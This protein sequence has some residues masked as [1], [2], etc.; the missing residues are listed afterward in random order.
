MMMTSTSR[1]YQA[2]DEKEKRNIAIEEF[3]WK[4]SEIDAFVLHQVSSKHTAKLVEVL[5]LDDSKIYKLYPEFGNIGPAS[6]PIALAK[7]VESGEIR[8]G[9]RVALMGIGSG[10][11]CSMMDV[12]W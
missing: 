6:V 4:L 1:N 5:G 9:A 2:A 12:I 11:N 10:L 3:N 7:A 8:P